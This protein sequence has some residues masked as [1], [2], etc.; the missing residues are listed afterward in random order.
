VVLTRADAMK[1]KT[2]E[3]ITWFLIYGGL[4]M[5]G[6]GFFIRRQQE[7]LGWAFVAAGVA[8]TL[9]GAVMLWLR[10]RRGEDD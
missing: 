2:F 5:V 9:G 1:N 6:L 3:A 10:S 7:A 8:D 4:L